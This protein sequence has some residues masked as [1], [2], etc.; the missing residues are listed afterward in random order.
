MNDDTRELVCGKVEQAIGILQEL[1]LDCWLT[2]VRET[3]GGGDPVLPLILGQPLT[4]QSALILTRGGDRIALVGRYEDA[5]VRSGGAWTDVRPYVEGI[6][7]PLRAALAA[8]DPRQVAINVSVDD[9]KAD[10]LTHGLWQLLHRHLAG[11]EYVERLTSAEQL[12][13]ALRGRKIPAEVDRLRRAI[14]TSASLCEAAARFARPGR[15]ERE[16]AAFMQAEVARLGLQTAWDP[17]HC[18]IV[19]TGPGSMLGHGTPSP[20]LAIEPGHIFHLDFGVREAGYCADMQRVWYVPADGESAPPD[21][22]RRAFDAVAGAI[23]AAARALRPGVDGWQVDAAARASLVAAGYPEYQH[24]TGHQVGQAAHDGAAVLGPRWE[25]YG[26]TPCM[27]VEPGNV[28]TLE[29]GIEDVDGRG[30]LGLEEMV[31]VTADGCEWLTEP[32][33]DLPL[34]PGGDEVVRRGVEGR[35]RGGAGPRRRPTTGTMP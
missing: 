10:G 23:Q 27:P 34:L 20:T 17:G 29:L 13:A 1:D 3:T 21:V 18:P 31:L 16:I 19:T 14:A 22:V 11:T 7:E 15:T 9:V 24:A 30:Y 8:I 25:R 32:Q 28:F 6:R 12:I 26:R 5:A 2:F 4:W 35:G 33:T